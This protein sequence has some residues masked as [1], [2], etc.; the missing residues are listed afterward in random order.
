M[1]DG[2]ARTTHCAGNFNEIFEIYSRTSTSLAASSAA[3]NTVFASSL[4]SASGQRDAMTSPKGNALA[5]WAAKPTT[6]VL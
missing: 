1:R 5:F 4:E 6:A 3:F 2:D